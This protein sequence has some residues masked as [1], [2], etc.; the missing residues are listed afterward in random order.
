MIRY[1]S[2]WPKSILIGLVV[3]I[4]AGLALSGCAPRG[5]QAK[6]WSGAAIDGDKI[7]LGSMEGRLVAMDISSGARLWSVPIGSP[8]GS[9][10]GGLGCG[11]PSASVAIYGTPAVNGELIYVG[12][13]IAQGNEESR[14]KVYAFTFDREEPRWVYPRE[15]YLGGPIVG[16]LVVANGKVYFG[17]ADGKVYALD[18]ADGRKLAEFQTGDKIWSTPAVSGDTVYIGSFDRNLY[19]LD[20]ETLK[21]VKWK[22]FSTESAIVATPV[23]YNNTVYVGSFDRYLYAINTAGGSLKWKF[24]TDSWF[25]ARPI[26]YDGTIYAPSLDHKVYVLNAETGMEV[27]SAFELD[28]PIS[29]SPVLVE[30]RVIVASEAGRIYSIDTVTNTIRELE[31]L[32]EK[33]QAPLSVGEGIVYVHTEDD[34]FYAVDVETGATQQF[35]F[36]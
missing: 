21:P 12:G 26:I 13:Y 28:S 33:I 36:K 11:T 3:L 24:L 2:A 29:S 17:A 22:T 10:G 35:Y 14:G 23:V 27:V 19:A 25:W 18:A 20:A 32:E 7:F 1:H 9:G 15:G 30:D 31:N 16:G 34:A 8:G 5:G 4:M 6:G